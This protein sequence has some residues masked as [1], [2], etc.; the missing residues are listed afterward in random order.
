[1]AGWCKEYMEEFFPTGNI[2]SE[3][4]P[5]WICNYGTDQ[6]E[7]QENLYTGRLYLIKYVIDDKVWNSNVH[8]KK[9]L[10]KCEKL[11]IIK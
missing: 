5:V 8:I 1:M 3:F 9:A 4:Q 10:F 2:Q 11:K 7:A 6:T